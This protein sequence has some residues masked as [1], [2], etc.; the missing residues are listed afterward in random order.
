MENPSVINVAYFAETPEIKDT[1]LLSSRTRHLTLDRCYA[2]P[3]YENLPIE[4]KNRIYD[5]ILKKIK[6][7]EKEITANV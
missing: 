2:I 6:K 7:E 4:E 1:V 3:G 5:K